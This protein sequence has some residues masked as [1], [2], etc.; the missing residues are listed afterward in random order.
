[1][2]NELILPTITSLL[3]NNELQTLPEAIFAGL[4]SLFYL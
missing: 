2:C 4:T 1:M 3:F